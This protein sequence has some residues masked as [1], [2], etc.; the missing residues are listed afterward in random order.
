ML[1]KQIVSRYGKLESLCLFSLIFTSPKSVE[2]LSHF[3]SS[4]LCSLEEL[5]V[6][7]T[8][9]W[10]C[11]SCGPQ[12]S[13]LGQLKDSKTWRQGRLESASESQEPEPASFSRHAVTHWFSSIGV[14]IPSLLKHRVT[15]A[16]WLL[17]LHAL[18]WL[19]RPWTMGSPAALHFK[20][21]SL[22]LASFAFPSQI[23]YN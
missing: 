9:C 20:C 5:L 23:L 18:W 4:H 16:M 6:L 12:G 17:Q 14:L 3:P 7:C 15:G 11:I 19:F 13:K 10:C 8:R 22:L 1:G 2:T 21:L